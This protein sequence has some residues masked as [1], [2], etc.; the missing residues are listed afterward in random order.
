MR[1][2]RSISLTPSVHWAAARKSPRSTGQ[3]SSA[4]AS[5]HVAKW[6]LWTPFPFSSSTVLQPV[7]FLSLFLF[8]FLLGGG[9]LF[10]L[11]TFYWA[12][13]YNSIS[14]IGKKKNGLHHERKVRSYAC[15]SCTR[16]ICLLPGGIGRVP[17]GVSFFVFCVF[18]LTSFWLAPIFCF[19]HWV[20]NL[21]PPTSF[22][23]VSLSFF[24]V[25][26]PLRN[27]KKKQGELIKILWFDGGVEGVYPPRVSSIIFCFFFVFLWYLSACECACA[28]WSDGKKK[29]HT[30]GRRWRLTTKT[31]VHQFGWLVRAEQSHRSFVSFCVSVCVHCLPFSSFGLLCFSRGLSITLSLHCSNYLTVGRFLF[32]S[33]FLS[34]TFTEFVSLVI[35]ELPLCVPVNLTWSCALACAIRCSEPWFR[36]EP[37]NRKKNRK[38]QRWGSSGDGRMASTNRCTRQTAREVQKQRRSWFRWNRLA[39]AAELMAISWVS[40]AGA[41][42]KRWTTKVIKPSK[43]FRPSSSSIRPKAAPRIKVS[44]LSPVFDFTFCCCLVRDAVIFR[45]VFVSNLFDVNV[46]KHIPFLVLFICWNFIFLRCCIFVLLFSPLLFSLISL[47]TVGYN[48]LAETK[49]KKSR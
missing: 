20:R 14:I 32:V 36:T 34:A 35:A 33:C 6:H 8:V 31:R 7:C 26:P 43:L 2:P 27:K 1:R 30:Q 25:L 24:F 41:K 18:H 40:A 15:Y 42:E 28:T 39:A 49:K 37:Q 5:V 47:Q 3:R 4:I 29:S 12:I 10:F 16:I 9:V 19:L 22:G 17:V 44:F 48:R 23:S 11:S 21:N 13:L 45:F 38:T 46:L